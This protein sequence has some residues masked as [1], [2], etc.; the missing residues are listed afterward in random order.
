MDA[1]KILEELKKAGKI[2]E[3]DILEVQEATPELKE[4]VDAFHLLLALGDQQQVY[5]KESLTA[6]GWNEAAHIYWRKITAKII[7]EFGSLDTTRKALARAI[8]TQKRLSREEL[9]LLDCIR[10]RSKLFD[11]IGIRP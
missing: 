10:D 4:L 7:N 1:A 9:L 5:H 3:S 6:E 11:W 8:E 2:S